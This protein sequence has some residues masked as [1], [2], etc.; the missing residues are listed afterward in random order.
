M[1]EFDE[2]ID[3]RIISSLER[4]MDFA[5]WRLQFFNVWNTIL[6]GA[7]ILLFTTSLFISNNQTQILST[8]VDLGMVAFWGQLIV[9][10]SYSFRG[11]FFMY[12]RARY[13]LLEDVNGIM[14]SGN[15]MPYTVTKGHETQYG[16]HPSTAYSLMYL[17]S[18]GF[19]LIA[20]VKLYDYKNDILSLLQNL[21]IELETTA[22]LLDL[23][24]PGL[25]GFL[26][27]IDGDI[28]FIVYLLIIILLFSVFL[29]SIES[30]LLG[31]RRLGDQST[32]PDGHEPNLTNELTGF[33]RICRDLALEVVLGDFKSV[34]FQLFLH[35]LL[36]TTLSTPALIFFGY[37]L[38]NL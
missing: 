13:G 4:K 29:R 14:D 16:V 3:Y 31:V 27:N 18:S 1:V 36:A 23:M 30:L 28:I 11:L 37:I 6:G 5:L 19:I 10:F 8:I 33:A 12:K 9:I 25:G 2:S 21:P 38:T 7:F 34:S 20:S 22:R 17:V 26:K 32:L 15:N 35:I 24:R